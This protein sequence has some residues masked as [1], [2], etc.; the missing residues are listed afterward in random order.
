M[1]YDLNNQ[2]V[3]M[4]YSDGKTAVFRYNKRGVIEG[5][6][7]GAFGFGGSVLNQIMSGEKINWRKAANGAVVGAV[8]RAMVT[9]GAGIPLAFAADLAAGTLGSI[10]EQKLSTGKVSARRRQLSPYAMQGDPRR[11]CGSPSPFAGKLGYSTASGYQY[12]TGHG[13]GNSRG[14]RKKFSLTDFGKSGLTGGLASLSFYRAGKAFEGLRDSIRVN[15][16]G[17]GIIEGKWDFKSY[18]RITTKHFRRDF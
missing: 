2:S 16:G 14:N 1:R 9:S 8:R 10:L 11:D 13:G 4:A 18:R 17:L 6:V 15:E 7:G 5:A 3:F 12:G